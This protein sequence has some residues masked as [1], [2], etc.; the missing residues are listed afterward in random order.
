[1][2]KDDANQAAQDASE[3]AHEAQTAA[4][5][6]QNSGNQ[7]AANAA[8]AAAEAAQK[9]ANA[10]HNQAASMSQT[11]LLSGDGALMVQTM[12]QCFQ[13]PRY[14]LAVGNTTTAL[15]YVYWD[16]NYFYQVNLTTPYIQLMPVTSPMPAAL[17]TRRS[18]VNDADYVDY[19]LALMV[20]MLTLVGFLLLLQQVMGRN[21]HVIRPLYKFQRFLF[22]PMHYQQ[23]RTHEGIPLDDE[24]SR[25]G[26]GGRAHRF[27]QDVIPLSMGGRMFADSPSPRRRRY[28]NKTNKD[29]SDRWANSDHVDEV[30]MMQVVAPSRS[31]SESDLELL[32]GGG[33]ELSLSNGSPNKIV[34]PERLL[35]D[36]D[37]VDLPGLSSSSKVAMP[38]GFSSNGS[39]SIHSDDGAS[40]QATS[41]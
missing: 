32:V 6:A 13:N 11:A 34:L 20:L 31:M 2:D 33:P 14:G 39:Q 25:G 19:V 9:A 24:S 30:E 35:R 28:E 4:Q 3:A 41:P 10:T 29:E 7:Q 12:A 16:G 36:P 26:G 21:Y 23:M 18:Q 15:A 37:L 22:D 38:V 8:Q 5:D 40:D 27:A 1:L 17:Q